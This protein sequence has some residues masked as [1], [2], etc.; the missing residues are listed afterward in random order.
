MTVRVGAG[1]P[2]ADS[3]PLSAKPFRFGIVPLFGTI[4][5]QPTVK[6]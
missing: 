5:Q 6:S 3:A 1:H 2:F 4:G